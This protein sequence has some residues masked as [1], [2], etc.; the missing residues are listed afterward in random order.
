MLP[1]FGECGLGHPQIP[2]KHRG[3]APR[4]NGKCPKPR[5]KAQ[6]HDKIRIIEKLTEI[7]LDA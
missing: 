3:D 5:T 4:P 7:M 1:P 6:L 2:P